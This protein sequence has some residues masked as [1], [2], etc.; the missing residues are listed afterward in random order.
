MTGR[1]YF[2]QGPVQKILDAMDRGQSTVA[3]SL[4]LNR[5][6]RSFEIQAGRLV[7]EKGL[8]VE[9]DRLE[10][11]A[12]VENKVFLLRDKELSPLEVRSEGYY[13]L[14]PTRTAPTLEINGIKMHRSKDID[15]LEDARLKAGKI[16]RSGDVVLDTCGGLGYSALAVLRAGAR[17]VVSTEKSPEVVRI[18]SLNPWLTHSRY[19]E[20]IHLINAD[21]FQYIRG[22][23]KE[24]FDAVLHDP[25]RFTSATGNLYGKEFYGHLFRV[26][27]PNGRL[28]HYTGSPSRIKH[29]DRFMKNAI[30]RLET[31]GFGR[32]EFHVRL[33]GILGLK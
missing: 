22:L 1:Y 29:G 30:K 4:D 17:K 28:F 9:K 21:I 23:E 5:S 19:K 10:A 20:G 32:L 7:L 15:P 14:V 31:A 12:P 3:V 24:S 6:V 13:K 26:M 11:I 27:R 18:R 16:A 2:F 25:P 33:Q 8:T